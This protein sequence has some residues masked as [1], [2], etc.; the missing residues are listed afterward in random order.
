[1]TRCYILSPGASPPQKTTRFL[2]LL[3]LPSLT[4]Q[5]FLVLFLHIWREREREKLVTK[6]KN[7]VIYY[8]E[9][10][11][12]YCDTLGPFGLNLLLLKLKTETEN[13]VAK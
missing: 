7:T 3:H 9:A 5:F 8:I 10:N 1:M 11:N 12:L 4:I 2:D 6:Y 13:T